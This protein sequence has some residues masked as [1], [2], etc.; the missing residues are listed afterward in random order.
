MQDIDFEE[1]QE[2]SKK[3]LV[4]GDEWGVR[5]LMNEDLTKF[6]LI[7]KHWCLESL[8][9]YFVFY[10]RKALVTPKSIKILY[11]KGMS[12]FKHLKEQNKPL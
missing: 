11:K 2:F 1:F 6:F 10:R 8:G 4:Q 9:F 3:F 12:L 7:E 5:R